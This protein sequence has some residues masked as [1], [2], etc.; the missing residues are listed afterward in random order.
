MGACGRCGR[1]P[2]PSSSSGRPASVCGCARTA[3]AT[4]PGC[5][6]TRSTRCST[7]SR[8]ATRRSAASPPTRRTNCAPRWPRSARSSRSAS[9]SALTPE[10]LDLLSRQLLATN[11]R[12]EP[13]IE[14]L[15]VLA[16]TERGLMANGAA[17]ARPDRRGHRRDVAPVGGRA[18]HPHRRRARAGR[19]RRRAAA[20]RAAGHQP[21]PERDQVQRARRLGPGA[22]C[23]RRAPDV[24]NSGP[25]VPPEQVAGLFEP[26]RRAR[27]DRLDH[28]GG[29]GLGLTIARSVVAAHGGTIEAQRQSGRWPHRRGAAPARLIKRA[30]LDA[31]RRRV[32]L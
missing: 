4:R 20:A 21:R 27:G 25:R 16:E 1:W 14:G 13:L 23:D 24:A 7:G 26:F 5:S 3:R 6:P 22:H 11:E 18:R 9:R 29:V 28:G 32:R 17:A 10:Q 12:N 19:G 30:R 8:K 2:T 15:L 31:R